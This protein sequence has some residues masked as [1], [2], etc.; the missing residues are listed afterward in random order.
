MPSSLDL[1][2]GNPLTFT[3]TNFHFIAINLHNTLASRAA[4]K[5]LHYVMPN[6]QSSMAFSIEI[7]VRFNCDLF[8][9]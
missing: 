3:P 6:G 7:N 1:W 2:A 4:N 9:R 8:A 5:S